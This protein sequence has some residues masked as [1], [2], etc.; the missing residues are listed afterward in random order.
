M[1]QTL[2]Q[3]EISDG[4]TGNRWMAVIYDNDTTTR[5]EVFHALMWAT[6]C[7]E[8]E[9]AIEM[10]EAE[11]Y[12]KA[13]VHFASRSDCE[14]VAEVMKSIGVKTEVTPEWED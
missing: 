9:A 6:G 4:S 14:K 13:P 7:D 12:G 5:D 10:W 1:S 8:E 11:V 2:L 3:P